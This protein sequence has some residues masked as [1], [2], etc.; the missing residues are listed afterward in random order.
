MHKRIKELAEEAEKYAD[1]HFKGEFF[2]TEAYEQKFAELIVKEC[3]KRSGE[4][5][6]PEVGKGLMKHFGVTE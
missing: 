6:Q 3:A 2:W 5:G 1:Y 4:L